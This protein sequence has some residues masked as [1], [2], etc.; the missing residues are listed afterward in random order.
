[1]HK[2]LALLVREDV[3]LNPARPWSCCARPTWSIAPT[4]ERVAGLVAG[5]QRMHPDLRLLCTGPWPP[6]SFAER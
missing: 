5:L 3:V 4:C 1:M 6:Y 2:P